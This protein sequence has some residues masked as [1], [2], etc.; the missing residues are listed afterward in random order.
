MFGNKPGRKP[1][2]APAGPA[3]QKPSQTEKANSS[4]RPARKKSIYHEMFMQRK[5]KHRMDKP[6]YGKTGNY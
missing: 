6:G 2:K 3:T 4:Y 1:S 5:S